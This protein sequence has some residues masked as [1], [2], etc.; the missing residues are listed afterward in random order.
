MTK[1]T[2]F[3]IS[4]S[5]FIFF[6]LLKPTANLDAT[7]E[8]EIIESLKKY[9]LRNSKTLVLIAH[10]LSTVRDC[11]QIVV[12]GRNGVLEEGSHD[13]LMEKREGAYRQ[14]VNVQEGGASADWSI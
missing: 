11:D 13:V 14:M 12:V 4:Y 6:T 5:Y 1:K 8:V 2:T 7:N 9:C 10:R 3:V